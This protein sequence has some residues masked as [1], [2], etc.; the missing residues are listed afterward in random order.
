M[1]SVDLAHKPGD[2]PGF[3]DM[4]TLREFCIAKLGVNGSDWERQWP[5][6]L[7]KES[8]ALK[9]CSNSPK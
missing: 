2:T 9:V 1:S 7:Q 5:R 3:I 6:G 4:E 8:H